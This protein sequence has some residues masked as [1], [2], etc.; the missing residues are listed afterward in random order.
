MMQDITLALII[1]TIVIKRMLILYHT[2]E[3]V[4]KLVTAGVAVTARVLALAAAALIL[5]PM[6]IVPKNALITELERNAQNA[7]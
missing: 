2:A 3:N 4:M 6:D 5:T 1:I 7:H